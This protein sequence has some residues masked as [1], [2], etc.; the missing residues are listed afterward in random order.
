[1]FWLSPTNQ[2]TD[3]FSPVLQ[4]WQSAVPIRTRILSGMHFFDPGELLPPC[5]LIRL[6]MTTLTVLK[7]SSPLVKN[8]NGERRPMHAQMRNT[9]KAQAQNKTSAQM[10]TTLLAERVEFLAGLVCSRHGY[11]DHVKTRTSARGSAV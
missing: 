2:E 10:L 11:M 9:D 7:E 6:N 4:H 1:M 8:G 5:E 3:L